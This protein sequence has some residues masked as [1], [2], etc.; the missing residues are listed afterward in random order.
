MYHQI[1]SA[2]SPKPLIKVYTNDKEYRDIFIYSKRIF[3]STKPEG[4][5]IVLITDD[6]TLNWVLEKNSIKNSMGK[7]PIL[8]VTDYRFLKKSEDIVGAFYWRKGRAQLLFVENRLKRYS[9]ILPKE[10]QKF[11]IDM[12]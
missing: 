6:A 11:T 7:K 12:L 10:Y 2:L 1:F 3:L 9:I 8:F 5:D 4:V